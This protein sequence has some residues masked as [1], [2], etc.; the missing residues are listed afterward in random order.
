VAEGGRALVWDAFALGRVARGEHWAFA[1]LSSE[2]TL[3][4]SGR[5]AFLERIQLGPGL[6]GLDPTAGLSYVGTL[7]C[8]APG[9]V[10]WKQ[11]A[12]ELETRPVPAGTRIGA[13][14]LARGGLALRV[15]A[16][17]AFSLA[18]VFADRWS[19]LRRDVLGLGPAD[20]RKN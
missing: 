16:P 7:V 15:L 8:L 3:R 11:L 2:V 17:A 19:V 14:P 12:A 5:L 9:D 6:A 13:S 4:V 20:L 1:R 10:A 18:E